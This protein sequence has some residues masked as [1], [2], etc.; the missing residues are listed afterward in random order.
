M[1]AD[2]LTKAL[3]KQR[4]DNLFSLLG[5]GDRS[6][7]IAC[8]VLFCT[9]QPASAQGGARVEGLQGFWF[10]VSV[11]FMAGMLFAVLLQRLPRLWFWV[12]GWF[13]RRQVLQAGE[14]QADQ[15]GELQVDPVR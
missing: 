2:S 10:W 3:P 1:V 11:A 15:L 7:L 13:G 9:F 8:S 4:L 5:F 14:L 12:R 6:K